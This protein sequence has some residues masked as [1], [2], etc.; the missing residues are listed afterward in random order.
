MVHRLPGTGLHKLANVKKHS[1]CQILG[2]PW[3][4]TNLI[5]VIV[6]ANSQRYEEEVKRNDDEDDTA[7]QSGPGKE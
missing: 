3:K 6:N 1:K 5:I 7:H 2:K 4:P